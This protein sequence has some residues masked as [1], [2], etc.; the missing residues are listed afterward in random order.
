MLASDSGHTEVVQV[1][2]SSEAQVDMQDKVS[3][4]INLLIVHES[5]GF[6]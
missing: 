2:L 3:H 4:S 1:L 6:T 5:D